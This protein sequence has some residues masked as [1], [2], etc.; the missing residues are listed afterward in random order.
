MKHYIVACNNG[1]IDY[2]DIRTITDS[3]QY[4]GSCEIPEDKI[5]EVILRA[6]YEQIAET[7]ET[8]THPNTGETV[9]KTLAKIPTW[10]EFLADVE[11][12]KEV[13]YRSADAGVW[14]SEDGTQSEYSNIAF[15]YNKKK[16]LVTQEFWAG[17]CSY[18]THYI[19]KDIPD[20]NV[21]YL[22]CETFIN[23][24]KGIDAVQRLRHIPFATEKEALEF[25]E[26]MELHTADEKHVWAKSRKE[27]WAGDA[28]KLAT[29][30]WYNINMACLNYEERAKEL[31]KDVPFAMYAEQHLKALL[32][33][34]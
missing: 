34:Y 15:I 6:A 20:E 17:Q 3:L 27:Y 5:E 22:V 24:N 26:N 7:K 29:D 19:I 21:R 2:H 10:E 31:K 13:V 4:E 25:I 9:E 23:P 14:T 1:G 32:E 18:D 8:E 11:A 16:H 33:A 28:A 12:N 30:S